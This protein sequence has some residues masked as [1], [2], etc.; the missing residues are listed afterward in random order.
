MDYL[1][2]VLE[3]LISI[4]SPTGFSQRA[5]AYVNQSLEEL[6]LKA[7]YSHKGSLMVTIKGKTDRV[8]T[9]AAH[10]DTLGAMVK[11]IQADG[12]LEF[13]QVGGYPYT[14][15]ERENV[16]V[17][18]RAGKTYEGTIVLNK[19]SV[20]CHPDEV[21][22]A[23]RSQE[24]LTIRL[25]EFAYSQEEVRELGIEV[26]DFISIDPRYCL[27]E[28]GFVKSRHIDDKAGVACLLA[29]IKELVDKDIRPEKT[30]KFY[31]SNYE[32]VGHGASILPEGT[33]D[34]IAVD[35]AAVD[36]GQNSRED[37]VTIC[38]MDSTGAYDY[39]LKEEIIQLAEKANLDYVV[40]IYP[41]YGSDGSAALRA[42]HDIRVGLIG[43][44][45]A[46]S[47]SYERTHVKG[48][49]NT[50]RLMREIALA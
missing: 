7:H 9:F 18:T 27:T 33:V 2:K 17:H 10:V 50:L 6:G 45:V 4:P 35:M 36:P 44:G 23:E 37:K 21:E 1:L 43:P 28:K 22:K 11:D 49:E 12:R 47:H 24:N 32:E 3:G 5:L 46:S 40:D 34:L 19:S 30:L 38:A 13:V 14:S 8:L 48:L 16:L 41:Y 15:V 25:D 31:F 29:L 39:D 20:H 26:G 42:G